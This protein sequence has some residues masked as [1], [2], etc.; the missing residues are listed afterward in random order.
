MDLTLF[1]HVCVCIPGYLTCE[2]SG[3]NGTKR[4]QPVT[5]QLCVK[6]LSDKPRIPH[7]RSNKLESAQQKRKTDI[8]NNKSYTSEQQ[9]TQ[10]EVTINRRKPKA[11]INQS[12]HTNNISTH[13]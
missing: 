2:A 5:T 10:T 9:R 12:L 7:Q 11:N 6:L 8:A 13:V 1:R 3:L 4:H